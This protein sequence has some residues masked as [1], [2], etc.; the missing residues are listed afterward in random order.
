MRTSCTPALYD[1]F[2]P[3]DSLV[4]K[5]M[6]MCP[7]CALSLVV[8]PLLMYLVSSFFFFLV[9]G[10]NNSFNR[11]DSWFSPFRFGTNIRPLGP[12]TPSSP[13][14]PRM[15]ERLVVCFGLGV[16]GDFSGRVWGRR[17]MSVRA[18]FTA[19]T[20]EPCPLR[21]FVCFLMRPQALTRR[22]C[23]HPLSVSSRAVERIRGGEAFPFSSFHPR[24]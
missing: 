9:F 6:R 2:H 16:S 7:G 12:K 20:F 15:G 5:H 13:P 19:S 21:F 18:P 1:C 3:V 11:S 24:S 22:V 23:S 8:W 10:D 17:D 4:W 14:A